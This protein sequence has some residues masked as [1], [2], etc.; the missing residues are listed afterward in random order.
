M[1]GGR[2]EGHLPP[3]NFD[4]N[5]MGRIRLEQTDIGNEEWANAL[6]L[7]QN[8]IVFVGEESSTRQPQLP[9]INTEISNR[10]NHRQKQS[11]TMRKRCAASAKDEDFCPEGNDQ[12]KA[13][14]N[15]SMASIVLILLFISKFQLLNLLIK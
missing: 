4:W 11:S 5:R 1:M 7:A 6:A 13:A 9:L 12:K 2:L 15:L 8:A 3:A 10:E 14:A